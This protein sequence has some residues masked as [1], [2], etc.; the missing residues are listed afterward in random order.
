MS[1]E[2]LLLDSSLFDDLILT[3]P[4]GNDL[5]LRHYVVLQMLPFRLLFIF[6]FFRVVVI[7]LLLLYWLLRL[8]FHLL[9]L[10]FFLLGRQEVV[11]G[12]KD[13]CH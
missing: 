10:L 2:G 4:L 3:K 12:D 13:E 7:L 6:L 1:V 8:I 11:D 5:F 9:W